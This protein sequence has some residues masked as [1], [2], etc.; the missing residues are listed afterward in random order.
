MMAEGPYWGDVP[1][2]KRM[3][4]SLAMALDLVEA[5]AKRVDEL[6]SSISTMVLE[7]SAPT[8][9]FLPRNRRFG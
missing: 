7:K 8:G 6:E 1:D 3:E 4:S 2:L 9:A 5:L